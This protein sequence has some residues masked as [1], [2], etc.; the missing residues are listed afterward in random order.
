MDRLVREWLQDILTGLSFGW[1]LC[2]VIACLTASSALERGERIVISAA[3]VLLIAGQTATFFVPEPALVFFDTACS[4]L[5]FAV[6]AWLLIKTVLKLKNS[7]TKKALCLSFA[8]YLCA[9]TG[10]YMSGGWAYFAALT[11]A[12]ICWPL[13]LWTIEKEVAAE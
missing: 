6:N 7:E 9:M 11:L 1:F 13:M 3:A 5:L 10:M 4:V 2:V 12:I 8:A